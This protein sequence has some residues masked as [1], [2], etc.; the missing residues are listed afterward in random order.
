MGL[1]WGCLKGARVLWV[2]RELTMP[3]VEEMALP[4]AAA[5]LF[6]H[7]PLLALSADG[8]GTC[9]H[10]APSSALPQS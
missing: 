9:N 1:E 2:K 6:K 8:S 3:H 4:L 7:V 10:K 5:L